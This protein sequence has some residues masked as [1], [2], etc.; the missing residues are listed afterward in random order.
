MIII[1][2]DTGERYVLEIDP[3]NPPEW[4]KESLP[5]GSD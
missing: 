2:Y 4:L 1:I 3:D 5:D